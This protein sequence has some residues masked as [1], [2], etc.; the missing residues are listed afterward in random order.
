MALMAE[1]FFGSVLTK[2]SVRPGIPKPKIPV[3]IP[4]PF[5]KP[6]V[7]RAICCLGMVTPAIVRLLRHN[8][9]S[10]FFS[11]HVLGTYIKRNG[12]HTRHSHIPHS[13]T[14]RSW[15]PHS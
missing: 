10:I 2:A 8:S 12:Q 5:Q 14:G 6:D 15:R 11:W 1:S 4:S 7:A 9:V 3:E 13:S